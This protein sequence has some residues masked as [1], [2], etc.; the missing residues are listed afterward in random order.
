MVTRWQGDKVKRGGTRR[1]GDKETRGQWARRGTGTRWA[2]ERVW[3]GGIFVDVGV[4]AG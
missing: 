3:D 4:A 2:W 1:Q